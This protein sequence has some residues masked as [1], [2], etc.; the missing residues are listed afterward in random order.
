MACLSL[1]SATGCNQP[2]PTC[3]MG[4]GA[5]SAKFIAPGDIACDKLAGDTLG[6]EPYFPASA[7]DAQTIDY[8]E[9]ATIAIRSKRMSDALDVAERRGAPHSK[10]ALTSL[11]R[12]RD[13]E[14]SDDDYCIAEDF[15]AAHLEVKAVDSPNPD[16]A[17]DALDITYRWQALQVYT[18]AA[19]PGTQFSGTVQVVV[20][21]CKAD[22][23]VWAVWPA[24]S[25][26]D[27]DGGPERCDQGRDIG[28]NPDFDLVCDPDLFQCVPR[29]RPPS[30]R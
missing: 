16:K 1:L 21:G 28:L 24:V 12:F 5:W 8:D 10:D 26:A 29:R 15:E 17:V 2:R 22:Y 30:L 27:A 6:I 9:A 4:H 20:D 23:D 13:A 25:C 3:T 11:G 19:A 18:T 7:Q 14:P